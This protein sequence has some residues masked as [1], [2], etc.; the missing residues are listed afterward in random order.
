MQMGERDVEEKRLARTPAPSHE[1]HC[2]LGDLAVEGAAR[3]EVELLHGAGGRAGASLPDVR[4]VVE[5]AALR[6]VAR[7]PDAVP[8]VEALMRRR[9]AGRVAR[10]PFAVERARISQRLQVLGDRDLPERHARHRQPVGEGPRPDAVTTGE[11]RR[12]RW[13]AERLDVE[14]REAQALAGERVQPWRRDAAYAAVDADFPE[15]EIVGVHDHDVGPRRLRRRPR[16]AERRNRKQ[17]DNGSQGSAERDI[18]ASLVWR[19]A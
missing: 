6:F 18:R 4:R 16:R 1:V 5:R 11:K 19:C 14:V 15:A 7:V 13:R 8:L 3:L 9:A 12:P 2:P 17:S 10:V